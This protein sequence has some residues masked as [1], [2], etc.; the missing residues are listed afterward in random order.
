MMQKKADELALRLGTDD[1]K[2]LSGWLDRFKVRHGIS[3]DKIICKSVSV[4]PKSVS[5]WLPLLQ[6]VLS[7]YQP[8][9]VYNADELGMFYNLMPDRTHAVKEDM[10]KGTKRSKEHLTVLYYNMDGS[11]KMKPLIICKFKKPRGF[12][13]EHSSMRLRL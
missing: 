12:K 2:C 3:C 1:L 6:H 8:H 10:C 9:D 13:G 5:E 11:D 4:D 7:R